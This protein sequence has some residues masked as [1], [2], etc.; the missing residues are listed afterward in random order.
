MVLLNGSRYGLI[1]G[2][3]ETPDQESHPSASETA[4][5]RGSKPTEF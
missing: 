5:I 1:G 4:K 2:G 3:Q